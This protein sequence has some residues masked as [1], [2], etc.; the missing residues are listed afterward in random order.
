[1]LPPHNP[2][3]HNV[4]K[5]RL[6]RRIGRIGRGL[7]P[8]A[9]AALRLVLARSIHTQ[10]TA[11]SRQ[12]AARSS[13]APRGLDLATINVLPQQTPAGQMEAV[14]SAAGRQPAWHLPDHQQTFGKLNFRL[15]PTLNP[16]ADFVFH[17]LARL[18]QFL[19][20]LEFGYCSCVGYPMAASYWWLVSI[21]SVQG[22][23]GEGGRATEIWM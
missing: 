1:M 20:T 18:W 2:M 9:E 22:E 23:E 5:I 8:S 19:S 11:L 14:C 16:F 7:S 21:I 17:T 3:D 12:S 4:D 10:I 15:R 13:A 6:G